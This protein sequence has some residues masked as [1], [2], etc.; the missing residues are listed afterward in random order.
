MQQVTTY[1]VASSQE[2]A[3][4]AHAGSSEVS[5]VVIVTINGSCWFRS[6]PGSVGRRQWN[7][8][9]KR[10]PVEFV[11]D[12]ATGRVAGVRMEI[13]ELQVSTSGRS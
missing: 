11:A 10:T 6:S 7:L 2:K 9:F 13:N 1:R 4:E 8:Y 5:V 12:E 3:H